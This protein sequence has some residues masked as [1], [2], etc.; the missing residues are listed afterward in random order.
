MPFGWGESQECYDQYQNQDTASLGH[1]VLAGGAG[2]AAMKIFEDRQRKE[3]KVVS[4]SFA[5]ELIAGFAAGEVDK[6]A[7]TKGE[8]YVREHRMRERAQEQG[9]HLYDQHYGQDDQYNPQQRQQHSSFDRYN[10]Y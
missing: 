3:G 2:F 6:L 10:N 9:E 4:H 7:E 8:D 5:K 1:E